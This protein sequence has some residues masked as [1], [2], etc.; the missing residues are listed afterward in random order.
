MSWKLQVGG[1][2]R[3]GLFAFS[4]LVIC[5]EIEG[6]CASVYYERVWLG[7]AV[8]VLLGVHFSVICMLLTTTLMVWKITNAMIVF[9]TL[10]RSFFHVIISF[11]PLL[12]HLPILDSQS[13]SLSSYSLPS[14]IFGFVL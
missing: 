11:S 5:D 13:L 8:L 10:K 2:R 12:Y 7:I 14:S 1:V 4:R 9:S 6:R 3:Q